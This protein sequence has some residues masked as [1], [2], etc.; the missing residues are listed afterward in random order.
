MNI[1]INGAFL[2]RNLTGIERFAFEILRALDEELTNEKICL[3]APKNARTLPSYKKI[4][5]LQSEKKLRSFPLWDIFIFP[6]LAKKAHALPFNFSNTAGIG[7][8]CGI[9]FIHDVYAKD[10]SR[11]FTSFRDKLVSLY[12][13]FQYW[14]IS[15]FAKKI[16]TVSDFS[17]DRIMKNY[18]V[19]E[20]R[21]AVIGNGWDHFAKSESDEKIFARLNSVLKNQHSQFQL[22]NKNYF[23]TLGSLSKRKNLV[24]ILKYAKLHP[25]DFFAISGKPI[26]S[27]VSNELAE[28]KALPNI[29]MTGYVSDGEVKALMKQCKAFLFP[30]YYEGFGIPP[31]E[32]LS[33]GANVFAMK[34]SSIPEIYD[35]AIFYLDENPETCS[36]SKILETVKRNENT[37]KKILENYTYKN[38]A[39]NLLHVLKPFATD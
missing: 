32:A 24:W 26:N 28:L 36:L 30:S 9:A 12:S 4:L 6:H 8:N 35:N 29:F 33:V 21:I 22:E 5:V 13:R 11:D 10:F 7:K 34:K 38:A 39:K 20:N 37:V 2:C 16:C 17:K 19:V 1:M 27:L 18:H 14:N 3:L 23:F 15:R 31:L 25:H